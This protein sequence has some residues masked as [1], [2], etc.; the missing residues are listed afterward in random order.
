[1]SIGDSLNAR[2]NKVMSM[3]NLLKN[4]GQP[5]P[6]EMLIT[7]IVCSL[8]P[9][10]NSIIVAWTNLHAPDRNVANHKIKLLQME[11]V[12]AL[13]GR[14]TVS[15]SA[16][17][18]RSSKASSQ[19]KKHNHEHYKDYIKELKCRTRWYTVESSTIGPP[20]VHIRVKIRSNSQIK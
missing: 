4:L 13:Q 11:K 19:N 20:N 7:K 2:V 1:M 9:I 8:P 5:L 14:E 6:K 16:F 12:M 18:T 17:F 10:Y 3:G 15:D